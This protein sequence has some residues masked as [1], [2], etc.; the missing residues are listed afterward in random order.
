LR[1]SDELLL[2][3]YQLQDASSESLGSALG[4]DIR[5]IE[6]Q[7]RGSIAIHRPVRQGFPIQTLF[8]HA[9]NKPTIGPSALEP[10]DQMHS[11]WL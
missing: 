9:R 4:V 1:R 6:K 11:T 3:S 7:R 5:E 8:S 10:Q 2:P